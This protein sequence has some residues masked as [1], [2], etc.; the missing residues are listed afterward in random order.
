MGHTAALCLL[1]D[2]HETRIG[3]VPSV[4][5]AYVTTAKPEAVTAHQTAG[6]AQRGG[7][8]IPG[9]HSRVRSRR[10][11]RGRLARDADKLETLLQAIE[12]ATQGHDAQPWRETS[13]NSL[14]IQHRERN[15]PGR[16]PAPIRTNGRQRSL[17]HITSCG[18]PL[19]TGP[20]DKHI[21]QI[22]RHAFTHLR[23]L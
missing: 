15:S 14:R 12:Y 21:A 16:S 17:R 6:D 3:D 20:R 9:T 1:H 4:G 5:R 8:G 18:Q 11:H 23:M 13:V 22:G 10:D 19:R 2:A 7:Q